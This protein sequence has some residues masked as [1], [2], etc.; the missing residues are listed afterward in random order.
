MGS[1]GSDGKKLEMIQ[2][3][4]KA[5]TGVGLIRQ[6]WHLTRHCPLVGPPGVAGFILWDF[7]VSQHP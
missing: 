5:L 3:T 4:D 2:V 7:C 1:E 6:P